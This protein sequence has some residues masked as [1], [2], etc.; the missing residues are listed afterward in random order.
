VAA[1]AAR[2]AAGRGDAALRQKIADVG[3]TCHDERKG[4]AEDPFA[5]AA[6][7]TRERR[8]GGLVRRL[9]LY[10]AATAVLKSAG[11][12]RTPKRSHQMITL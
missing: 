9:G 2:E 10:L 11:D 7:G 12:M 3:R 6:E 5:G 4:A 1:L 8:V